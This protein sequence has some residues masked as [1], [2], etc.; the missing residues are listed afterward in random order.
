MAPM[1]SGLQTFPQLRADIF[2]LDELLTEAERDV[3]A[4][5][6]AF[7]EKQAFPEVVELWNCAAYP[8]ELVAQLAQLGIGGGKLP[9]EYGGAGLSPVAAGLA[10]A[11][12]ARVDGSL[13][14]IHMISS[15]LVTDTIFKLGSE[16]QRQAYLPRLC[17]NEWIGSW[18]LTEA[19]AGS[20][21]GALQTTATAKEGGWLLH[22]SKR[23]IGNAPV[24]NVIVTWA[25][26]AATGAIHGFLVDAGTP[27]LQVHTM[28][29]KI[30][31][32][33]I[34][35]GDVEF[36]DVFLPEANRLPGVSK[37]SDI[38]AILTSSRTMVVWQPVGLA[39]GLYDVCIKYLSERRQ[40][41]T[42]LLASQMVQAKLM[43]ILGNCQAMGLLAWRLTRRFEAGRSNE[44]EAALCK[45]WCTRRGREC[46][47][48][49]RELL[50]GNGML[51]QFH[52]AKAFA[53][54][55]A[56]FTY[57]GTFDINLL[58]AARQAV[59]VSA[60]RLSRSKL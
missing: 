30:G 52:V 59:G 49:A 43:E 13:S 38:T 53:D 45:A 25:R 21:A 54:V 19:E 4:R 9:C 37:L 20:D 34:Q 32:R 31:L 29:G 40:F 46:A 22:G 55:E 24:A 27:G 2:D 41:G 28:G 26:N 51:T 47:A 36:C 1:A 11:E 7:A 42:S 8:K 39:W 18:A 17:S 35:N 5:V 14:A 6:R 33:C 56:F 48:L 44:G 3:R 12:L 50:G 23:W 58:V 10:L 57:E 15:Y 16:D 60:V